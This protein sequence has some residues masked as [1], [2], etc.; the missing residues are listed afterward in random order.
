MEK[1]SNEKP[2][3]QRPK[4]IAITGAESTGKSTLSEALAK[5]YGVPFQ[6]EYARE[7]IRNLNR[8]YTFKDVEFIARKQLQ[9]YHELIETGNSP[10]ILDT[11]LLITKIWFE[12][13]FKQ[14]PRWVDEAIVENPVDLF[15]V[16]DIDLPWKADDVR[17]NGGENRVWLQ[18]RYIEAL[19]KHHF[20]YRI[21]RGTGIER[22]QNAIAFIDELV[23]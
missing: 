12:V 9:Q 17:E 22:L 2:L 18:H 13:V 23:K 14:V 5:H 11:W 16:C 3:K 1:R 19:K 8:E 7:Y 21:V 6:A 10:A 20:K 4:I 15:L